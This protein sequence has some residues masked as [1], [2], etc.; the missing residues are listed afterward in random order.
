MRSIFPAIIFISLFACKKEADLVQYKDGHQL[1]TVN[2]VN[3]DG[4]KLLAPKVGINSPDSIVAGDELVAKIFL[5]DS[6]LEIADAFVGCENV[7]AQVV[8]T[9]TYKVSGCSTGLVVQNDT[10]FI[11]FRP[12]KLGL[13]EFQEITIL[14]R[15][16]E[17]V[18][19]II[20]YSFTYR[21]VD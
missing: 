2:D 3:R 8:D 20:K 17:R 12:S 6:N 21:V 14:T 9:T 7:S 18:F 1:L 19:R 4:S 11:G 5:K 10:I 15:D 16:N 13:N